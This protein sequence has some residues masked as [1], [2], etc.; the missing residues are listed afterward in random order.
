VGVDEG[1]IKSACSNSQR[2]PHT[3]VLIRHLRAAAVG[4]QELSKPIKHRLA[5]TSLEQFVDDAVQ[6]ERVR[7]EP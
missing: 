3:H 1:L 2:R 5:C 4:V 7:G 6:A